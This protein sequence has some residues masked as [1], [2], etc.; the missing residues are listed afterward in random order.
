MEK[1]K[2]GEINDIIYV[3]FVL[4]IIRHVMAIFNNI[5]MAFALMNDTFSLWFNI[6]LSILMITSLLLIMNKKKMGV[7]LFVTLQLLSVVFNSIIDSDPLTHII[8][9]VFMCGLLF[10]VLQLRKNGISA[11]KVIMNKAD[12]SDERTTV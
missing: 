1:I 10:L 4:S 3:I 9:A 6:L 12:K 5:I 7:Y 2:K 11:W 8:P